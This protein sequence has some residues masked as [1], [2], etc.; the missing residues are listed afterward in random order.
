MN[1]RT[2]LYAIHNI[3][4]SFSFYRPNGLLL[5]SSPH[6]DCGPSCHST[7]HGVQISYSGSIGRQR[8]HC[9]QSVTPSKYLWHKQSLKL[10]YSYLMLQLNFMIKLYVFIFSLQVFIRSCLTKNLVYLKS[11]IHC[12]LHNIHVKCGVLLEGGEKT[13]S[14]TTFCFI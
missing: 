5:L 6:I 4:A 3:S 11:D 14:R 2:R 7:G 8:E 12:D 13:D 1:R 10:D 9:V